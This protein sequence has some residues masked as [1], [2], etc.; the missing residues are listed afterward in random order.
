[1]HFPDVISMKIINFLYRGIFM[2]LLAITAHSV[3]AQ[4]PAV[5]S[6]VDVLRKDYGGISWDSAS[7][8]AADVNCDGINDI[9]YLGNDPDAAWVGIVFGSRTQ[10]KLPPGTLRFEASGRSHSTICA[11]PVKFESVPLDCRTTNGSMLPGC[12]QISRCFALT[13]T[14]DKCGAL[15][16][17][18][19]AKQKTMSSRRK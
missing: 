2:L 17:Y 9:A 12:R 10:T 7:R 3:C 13:L 4:A 16:V 8:I 5:P 11:K 14:D 1:M 19:D 15:H 6:P 18:W